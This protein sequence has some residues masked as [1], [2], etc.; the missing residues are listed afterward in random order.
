MYLGNFLKEYY[1]KYKA[2]AKEIR[3]LSKEIPY[4][5]ITYTRPI[6]NG[7]MDTQITSIFLYNLG[8]YYQNFRNSKITPSRK[9]DTPPTLNNLIIELLSLKLYKEAY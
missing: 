1:T 2:A 4:L 9:E 3:Q 7:I 8:N 6:R 5:N